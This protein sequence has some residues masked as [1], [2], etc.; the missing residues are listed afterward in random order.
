M[1]A[2]EE[3]VVRVSETHLIAPA[4]HCRAVLAVG[5]TCCGSHYLLFSNSYG[6]MEYRIGPKLKLYGIN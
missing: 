2:S 4:L 5:G 1:G 6:L 3:C